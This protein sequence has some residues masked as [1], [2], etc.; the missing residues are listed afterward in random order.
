MPNWKFHNEWAVKMGL[1]KEVANWVN[2]REDLPKMSDVK[3]K[4][5]S[6]FKTNIPNEQP[7]YDEMKEKGD[8]YLRAWLLHIL[9]D[10]LEDMCDIDFGHALKEYEMGADLYVEAKEYFL[11]TPIL[12]IVPNDIGKFVTDNI[13]ELIKTIPVPSFQFDRK[14]LLT[15][16]KHMK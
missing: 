7:T 12:R 5:L 14:F 10:E 2:K 1:P 13:D 3:D 11:C 4:G 8:Y 15:D 9:I 16:F 6:K